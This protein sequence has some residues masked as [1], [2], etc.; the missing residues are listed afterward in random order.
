[1]DKKKILVV[2]DQPGVQLLLKT[3]LEAEG[4]DIVQAEDGEKGLWQV[5]EHQP[6]LILTDVLMPKMNGIEFLKRLRGL[7]GGETVPVIV[8]SKRALMKDCFDE[9]AIA[10]FFAKPFDM[11]ALL[12]RI[13]AIFKKQGFLDYLEAA[14]K[15][16]Q[17]SSDS[18]GQRTEP[19]GRKVNTCKKCGKE[20]IAEV[21]HCHRCGCSEFLIRI[22][23][24]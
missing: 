17:E 22:V 4:Y 7:H 24:D 15:K 3:R 11:D 10:G 20:R 5:L 23:Y 8:I 6:D 9:E 1:M 14:R 13:A 19:Q 16:V 2:D 18:S 21:E 12:E